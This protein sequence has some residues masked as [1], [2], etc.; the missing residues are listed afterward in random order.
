M[1]LTPVMEYGGKKDGTTG[2]IE[3]LDIIAWYEANLGLT[4]VYLEEIHVVDCYAAYAR[5]KW[6]SHIEVAVFGT[7]SIQAGGQNQSGG[8]P[9]RGPRITAK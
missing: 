5:R 7:W 8:S 2:N 1:C 9:L 6:D 3:V 4:F